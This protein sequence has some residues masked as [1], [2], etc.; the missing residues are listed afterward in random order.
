MIPRKL[1]IV[2]F[3]QGKSPAF[4]CCIVHRDGRK[5][6]EIGETIAGAGGREGGTGF[7]YGALPLLILAAESNPTPIDES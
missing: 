2:H 4:N 5:R 1:G 3:F 7:Q 6:P